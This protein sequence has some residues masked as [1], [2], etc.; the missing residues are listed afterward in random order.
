MASQ[1]VQL[2]HT[3]VSAAGT[4]DPSHIGTLLDALGR[5]I[6]LAP[7]TFVTR[8]TTLG[9]N[10]DQS[11]HALETSDSQWSNVRRAREHSRITVRTEANETSLVLLLPPTPPGQ[12][13]HVLVR[14]MILVHDLTPTTKTYTTE[15]LEG[16][17]I[18]GAPLESIS[19]LAIHH[20]G[21]SELTHL[22]NWTPADEQL[23]Y[24]LRYV[25]HSD[26]PLVLNELRV[27]CTASCELQGDP[28]VMHPRHVFH[29]RA[30]SSFRSDS[31]P[32]VPKVKQD[33][34][35]LALQY[36]IQHMEQLSKSLET[37]VPLHRDI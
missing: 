23:V 2:Q 34:A 6:N 7:H 24:G 29:V 20:A 5:K 16:V 17:A 32:G 22:L 18:F 35:S 37:I 8:E 30:M 25:L 3:Q 14:S 13:P 12:H 4:I 33:K 27:Y 11:A 19:K 15:P 9:R 31:G 21:W 28:P 26:D 1:D 10:D 36:A